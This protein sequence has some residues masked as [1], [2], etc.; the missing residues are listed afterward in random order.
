MVV[1]VKREF[2]S[3]V[4]CGEFV[5]KCDAKWLIDNIKSYPCE[6]I[7]E[8]SVKI[9][10]NYCK[11][12]LKSKNGYIKRV[13]Y[14]DDGLG[15]MFLKKG[16][17]GFQSLKNE[18]RAFLCYRNYYDLDIS[19]AQPSVLLSVCKN[20][21]IE[22]QYLEY[23]IEN[24]E[25]II[26]NIIDL[27]NGATRKHL[28]TDFIA[29][30]N[31]SKGE[32][33]TKLKLDSK[34]KM[35]VSNF[36]EE[37][38]NTRNV[39]LNEQD[40]KI[41]TSLAEI[42]KKNYNLEGSAMSYF[43][44]NLENQVVLYAKK[45]LSKKGY[46]IGALVFDGLMVRNN[47]PLGNNIIKE[48]NK[49]IYTNTNLKIEFLIKEW[50]V[51]YIP[52]ET[53][54]TYKDEIIIENDEE[55]AKIILNDL[56]NEVVKCDSKYFYRKYPNTN[57]YVEDKS[58][59]Q[60]EINK[61]LFSIVMSYDIKMETEKGF[62]DYSK[63]T[64]G[65]KQIV[66]A[67]ISLIPNTPN[68]TKLLFNS[69]LGKLCFLNGYYDINDR[70]LKKYDNNC[71]TLKYIN[72]NYED[73]VPLKYF[74]ELNEYILNPI[75]GK[76]QRQ[77]ILRWF[78][79]ALF[80][81]MD[82]KWAV[83]LGNRNTGKSVLTKLFELTFDSYVK[84]FNAENLMATKV[85]NGDVAK[86]LSW[87]VPFQ[88]TRLYLSNEMKTIDENGKNLIL[89]CPQIKSISSGGDTKEAR[90]NYENESTF[91]LQG[92]MCLFMNELAKLSHSDAKENLYQYNFNTI[93]VDEIT[94]E[95]KNINENGDGC[96]F[97]L[98][99]DKIKD[100]INDENI[101]NAFIKLIIEN[102]G[103]N[104]KNE[105][106]NDDFDNDE[107]ND[108][109]KLNDYFEFTLNKKDIIKI[110]EFNDIL[111]DNGM[112]FSKSSV[113]LFLNKKGINDSNIPKEGRCY[114]GIKQIKKN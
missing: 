12:I 91:Q 77:N 99:N 38:V 7:C 45:Y 31:G 29:I 109:N 78:S 51:K 44:Q 52:E 94:D 74:S 83:G 79:R 84:V 96:K 110:K 36:I 4:Q 89:D 5:R 47:I 114:R 97:M 88:Y 86:K 26:K 28:K 19:N 15:R 56:N 72:K 27:N 63:K 100:I 57:I 102:Y 73:K 11:E 13:Y 33:I 62:K 9:C 95:H 67:I 60:K 21:N 104:I 34:V 40:N 42:N 70:K 18:Y 105:V 17:S 16:Q 46:E 30:M 87:I 25:T 10:V 93:F 81:C 108:M 54:L 53:E 37:M 39:I 20:K 58:H 22:H 61:K 32:E 80:G 43:L 48:L 41:F 68:F 98:K 82:K 55:G 76:E 113:K 64:S 66:E 14:N 106:N 1:E 59:N 92:N 101:Q 85:G 8:E 90:Q 112:K 50:E 2:G 65:C 23:Y 49:Y 111:N 103:D 24:R 6:K 71:Y 3:S 75:I 35:F 107:N 69:N